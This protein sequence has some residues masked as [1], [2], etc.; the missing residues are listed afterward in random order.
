V[1]QAI[2]DNDKPIGVIDLHLGVIELGVISELYSK[3]VDEEIKKGASF[4]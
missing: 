4:Q 1:R 3:V 2:A